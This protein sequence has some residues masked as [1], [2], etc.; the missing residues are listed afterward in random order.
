[1]NH[2]DFDGD[3][4]AD[5]AYCN[6]YAWPGYN[7]A[8]DTKRALRSRSTPVHLKEITDEFYDPEDYDSPRKEVRSSEERSDE[9]GM[10]QL[11]SEF[12]CASSC[13]LDSDATVAAT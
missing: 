2:Q 9:L 10:R 13:S 11:R 12:V 3:G 7:P 6:K 1:M 4:D 8:N 5:P